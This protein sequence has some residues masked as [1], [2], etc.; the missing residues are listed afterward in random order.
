MSSFIRRIQRMTDHTKLVSGGK[1]VLGRGRNKSGIGVGSRLGTVNP[2]DPCRTGKRK[3]VM[4]WRSAENAPPAKPALRLKASVRQTSAERVDAH[5]AKMATKAKRRA[6]LN[7]AA[8]APSRVASMLGLT[9][10][11][12]RR[13][14]KP[15]E[16][17]REIARRL[18]QRGEV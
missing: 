3:E 1:K 16:H 10:S 18:R 13:T 17:K 5:K 11:A 4:K 14:G 7:E 6:S 2:K 12:N 8:N 15:H 9:A